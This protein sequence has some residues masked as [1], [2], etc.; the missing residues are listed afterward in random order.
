MANL[1]VMTSSHSQGHPAPQGHGL[2]SAFSQS[3]NMPYDGSPHAHPSAHN[4][5]QHTYSQSFP[6]G[7][8]SNPGYARSFGAEGYGGPG[9]NYGG[10]P[11]IYTVCDERSSGAFDRA[12]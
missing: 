2:P 4:Q 10:K 9:R 12:C 1:E 7:P 8:V 3:F 11:Q 5:T 6:N